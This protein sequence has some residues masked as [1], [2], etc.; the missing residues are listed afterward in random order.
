MNFQKEKEIFEREVQ[1]ERWKPI[2]FVWLPR[3]IVNIIVLTIMR[4]FLLQ[5][6]S[7]S[8]NMH[9]D[10]IRMYSFVKN[11]EELYIYKWANGSEVI[12]LVLYVND[13]LLMKNDIPTLYSIK[14]WQSSQFFMKDLR[15]V[16]FILGMKI[17]RVRF[18][19]LL[20][21][22]KSTYIDTM[23]KWFSME[24]FNNG[25][26]LIDHEIILSKKDCPTTP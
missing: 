5:Q 9:F 22:S 25:H 24:N 4:Y 15:E 16:S 2:K 8:W 18:E 1:M 23:L 19:R 11:E 12:F 20:G 6:Y 3:N 26:L 7:Q 13:I 14:L 17:Y 10:K 21:L